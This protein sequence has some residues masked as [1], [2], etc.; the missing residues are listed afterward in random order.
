[1]LPKC[2]FL[3]LAILQSE[4]SLE[5][6]KAASP[7]QA[8]SCSCGSA[9]HMICEDEPAL[10]CCSPRRPRPRHSPTPTNPLVARASYAEMAG[11]VCTTLGSSEDRTSGRPIQPTIDQRGTY[12]CCQGLRKLTNVPT[13]LLLMVA[14]LVGLSVIVNMGLCISCLVG[15]RNTERL[16]K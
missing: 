4:L 11:Q 15:K 2:K 1:M 9:F 5:V 3:S 8:G 10:L 14:S 16:G 13:F 12:M 7:P 6:F